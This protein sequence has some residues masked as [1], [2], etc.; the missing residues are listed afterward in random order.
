MAK[1]YVIF[2][3]DVTDRDK[4]DAYAAKAVP[5]FLASGG[6]ALIAGPAE[7]VPEGEWHGNQTV[8]LEFESLDAAK[9]WYHSD[10]Y[11]AIIGEREAAATSNAVI[12]AGFEPG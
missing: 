2:T 9:A 7:E 3:E 12:F 6:K 5:T 1:G 10:G 8:V 4:M 11:Q